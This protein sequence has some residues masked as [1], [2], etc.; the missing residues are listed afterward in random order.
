MAQVLLYHAW[1]I[2]SPIGV[3]A[4]IM[5][6]AFLMTSSFTRRSEAGRMPFFVERWG[7]TFK[8]LLPLLTVTVLA[9]LAGSFAFLSPTRWH[10]MIRQ[11]FASMTYWENWEL[12]STSADYYAHDKGIAS[13]F[14]HLWSMSMQGQVFLLWPV[15]MTVAVILARKWNRSIRATIACLFAVIAVISLAWL[16]NQPPSNAGVYFDTRSR[17]WEFALGSAIA[18]VAPRLRVNTDVAR[19]LSWLGLLVL[20]VFCLVPIG[21]YPGPMAAFPMLATSFMLLFSSEDTPKSVG[22]L[23]SLRPLVALGNISYPVY[24]IHWPIF[25]FCLTITKQ[26]NLG[27]VDG[28]LL[29]AVSIALSWLLTKFF[30]NPLRRWK[31]PNASTSHKFALVGACLAC[32]LLPIGAAAALLSHTQHNAVE[33]LDEAHIGA[34]AFLGDQTPSGNAEPIPG[35]L[36]LRQWGR[37]P[38]E[39]PSELNEI[40]PSEANQACFQ[41]ESYPN[42]E[43]RIFIAGNSHAQQLLIPYATAF[44]ADESWGA[45]AVLKGACAW[46]DANAYDE[47]CA[48]WNEMLLDS[49]LSDPPDYVFLVVTKTATDS[50]DETLILGVRELIE[51]LTDAGIKVVGVRDNLRSEGDLYE[52]QP[53]EEAYL[54]LL[55]GCLLPEADYFPRQSPAETLT[56]IDGFTFFDFTDAYCQNGVCPTVIGNVA[57]YMDRNHVTK[58]YSETVAP[59]FLERF[60]SVFGSEEFN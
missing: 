42:A 15:L 33:N 54:P 18:A 9:T 23:L 56:D 34:A 46:G 52:C 17:L 50:P 55:G 48:K 35:P 41:S 5:I 39:C 27:F 19:A 1:T 20:V 6:S 7:N 44:L 31:W 26:D 47:D 14:Q 51:Q 11:A 58:A 59:F 30:D 60:K 16:L 4:F 49:V 8:R 37:F 2:G 57:V 22:R 43:H 32:G 12:V 29:I 38:D 45:R 25:V 13:P 24:L 36:N 10:E 40:F 21:T 28:A 53:R 3:D